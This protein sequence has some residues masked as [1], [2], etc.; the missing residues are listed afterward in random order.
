MVDPLLG[1]AASEAAKA[2][3]GVLSRLLG[4]TAD[5]MGTQL[6]EWYLRKNV[7]RVAKRAEAKVNTAA[8]GSIPPRVAAEVFEKAQWADDEFLAEYLSGVLATA[9]TPEGKD[10]RGVTWTAL[11]G[12]LSADQ[13]RLHYILYRGCRILGVEKPWNSLSE[14]LE[15]PMVSTYMDLMTAMDIPLTDEGVARLLEAAYGLHAEGLITD[16]LVHG[17]PEFVEKSQWNHTL[18]RDQGGLLIIGG[19]TRGASLFLQAHGLGKVWAKAI[20]DPELELDAQWP[21]GASVPSVNLVKLSTYENATD[22]LTA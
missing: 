19:S 22:P 21:D 17:S 8:K 4:P 15:D 16:Q 1:A 5:E 14:A 13:L 20:L 9:R 12:R 11:V 10:D 3:G 18:P 7:E 2:G 6:Q